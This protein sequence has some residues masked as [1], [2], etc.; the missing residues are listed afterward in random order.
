MI[1]K[2]ILIWMISLSFYTN[3]N[4]KDSILLLNNDS[5]K[6]NLLLE[7]SKTAIQQNLQEH[8]DLNQKAYKISKEITFKRGVVRA[9]KN[10]GINYYYQ[11]KIDSALYWYFQAITLAENTHLLEISNIYS[12]IGL[13]YVLQGENQKALEYYN[14][15]ENI[16]KEINDQKGLAKIIYLNKADI[17]RS[18]GLHLQA[19]EGLY[20][21][22]KLAT[23]LKDSFL[24]ANNLDFIGVIY[25]DM[26]DQ[27]KALINYQE[28]LAIRIK[29]NDEVGKAFSYNNI[30]TLF[31][32]LNN[33]QEV[34]SNYLKSVEI[35]KKTRDTLSLRTTYSN[36]GLAYFHLN[37]L[38]SSY[39]YFNQSKKIAIVVND[40]RQVIKSEIGISNILILENKYEQAIQKLDSCKN[41]A[42]KINDKKMLTDVYSNLERAYFLKN[43]FKNALIFAKRYQEI[44]DSLFYESKSK[45]FGKLQTKFEMEK[46]QAE[47]ERDKQEKE[48]I[49]Q[50]EKERKDN[51]QYS[52]IF[53]GILLVFGVLLGSGKFN[54][55]PKFAEGLI[56]FA[57]L[58]FFEFCLVLLDPIIDDWSS[59]EPIYKLLFNALLAGAIFPLHAFFEKT[60]KNKI[61]KK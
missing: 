22:T 42:E 13:A 28:A 5:I 49:A 25:E 41:F 36:L 59:G 1:K 20:E 55:S 30:G 50:E 34:I 43:N 4:N 23:I 9:A 11:G 24:I 40:E 29:I 10:T 33:Y 51:I 14:K 61:I 44:K 53:L 16:K 7:K 8:Y 52:L 56:F 21:S 45:D 37:K 32:G 12:N 47:E 31:L 17:Y 38:D 19:L 35:K 26:G 18:Q 57:F 58:I 48:R 27:E 54:I 60:L 6:V 15:S 2:L 46:K 39:R 3:A